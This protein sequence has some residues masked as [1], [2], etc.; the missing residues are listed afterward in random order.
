MLEP[1]LRDG[2]AGECVGVEVGGIELR[3]VHLGVWRLDV[4]YRSPQFVVVAQSRAVSPR[5]P[6]RLTRLLLLLLLLLRDGALY[7]GCGSRLNFFHQE[8]SPTILSACR[9]ANAAWG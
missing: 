6:L 3:G 8:R 2:L 9:R 5:R 4:R 1:L 7:G